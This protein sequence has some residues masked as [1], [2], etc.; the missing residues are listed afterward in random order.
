MIVSFI[1]ITYEQLFMYLI[2]I[3][4]EDIVNRLYFYFCK[5]EPRSGNFGV[6][7]VYVR[8]AYS[9]NFDVMSLSFAAVCARDSALSVTSCRLA[10][11]SSEAAATVS[12]FAPVFS[13]T[14]LMF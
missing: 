7:C 10:L 9:L 14:A 6:L 1:Q 5:Q 3:G 8:I 2:I 11:C 13:A 4:E 12:A